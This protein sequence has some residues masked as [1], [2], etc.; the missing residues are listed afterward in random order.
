VV[1]VAYLP[2]D[3]LWLGSIEMGI[4]AARLRVTLEE[5]VL[6]A[7]AFKELQRV[8]TEVLGPRA[9][10][11]VFGSCAT[12]MD[13]HGS[14]VDVAIL[15]KTWGGVGG[16]GWVAGWRNDWQWSGEGCRAV[17]GHVAVCLVGYA[18]WARL[19]GWGVC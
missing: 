14:D 6:R 7:I 1:T 4:L 17:W 2:A 8:V 15:G 13:W 19:L 12:K 11:L 3:N 10:C 5:R 9:R 18:V 16:L